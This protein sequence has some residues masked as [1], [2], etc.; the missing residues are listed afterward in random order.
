MANMMGI[1]KQVRL[2]TTEEQDFDKVTKIIMDLSAEQINREAPSRM[3]GRQG[4]HPSSRTRG[5]FVNNEQIE[6]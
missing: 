4:K 5:A 3:L 2:E 6:E 1:Q